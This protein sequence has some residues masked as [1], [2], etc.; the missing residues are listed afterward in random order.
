MHYFLSLF[1]T[2]FCFARPL[3]K[4]GKV[5]TTQHTHKHKQEMNIFLLFDNFHLC[6][7]FFNSLLPLHTVFISSLEKFQHHIYP[8]E[9]NRIA[10]SIAAAV[11]VAVAFLVVVIK[12]LIRI[13]ARTVNWTL[14]R[15]F[16]ESAFKT[17]FEWCGKE[18]L[19]GQTNIDQNYCHPNFIA[20]LSFPLLPSL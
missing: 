18:I 1:F 7:A 13:N 15:S 11:A 10:L 6:F 17:S 5:K 2:F 19:N 9:C 20:H 3:Q 14:D 16:L 8:N 12:L 4:P